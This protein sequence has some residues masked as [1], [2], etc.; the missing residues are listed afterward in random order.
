MRPDELRPF[1]PSNWRHSCLQLLEWFGLDR[2]VEPLVGWHLW[3]DCNGKGVLV[4]TCGLGTEY[5]H[6]EC[7]ISKRNH[8]HQPEILGTD[9]GEWSIGFSGLLNREGRR[10]GGLVGSQHLQGM[11]RDRFPSDQQIGR[12]SC[13][14]RG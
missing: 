2:S 5:A 7:D 13:R 10:L 12:A 11:E 1:D 4:S 14:G 8:D 3:P 6:S 9:R